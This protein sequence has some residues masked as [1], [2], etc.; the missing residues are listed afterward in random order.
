MKPLEKDERELLASVERGA[1]RSALPR[2]TV[3]KRYVRAA[4]K[5]LRK[6]QRVNIRISQP[7]LEGVQTKAFEEGI[8]YQTLITSILHKYVSGRLVAKR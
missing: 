4:R 8:P 3:S 6:D 2:N 5:T 1:W 7:D